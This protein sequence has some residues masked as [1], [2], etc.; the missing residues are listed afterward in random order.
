MRFVLWILLLAV[1]S[2]QAS[3]TSKGWSD[4]LS[5]GKALRAADTFVI[6]VSSQKHALPSNRNP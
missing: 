5:E 6:L 4:W 1:R 2:G 3:E